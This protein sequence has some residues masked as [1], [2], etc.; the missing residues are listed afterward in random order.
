MAARLRRPAA[1]KAKA[2]NRR[3]PLAEGHRSPKPLPKPKRARAPS[4][5]PPQKTR[6]GDKPLLT[7]GWVTLRDFKVE[8]G[9]QLHLKGVFQ[10]DE[11]ERVGEVEAVLRDT[12]GEWMKLALTGSPNATIREWKRAQAGEFY[13]NMKPL[14]KPIDP[15]LG[16]LFSVVELKEVDQ[17]V[18]PALEWKSNLID[19]IREGPGLPGLEQAAADLGY[20]VGGLDPPPMRPAGEEPPKKTQKTERTRTRE[21]NAEGKRLVGYG[22]RNLSSSL[23]VS[24]SLLADALRFAFSCYRHMLATGKE[25]GGAN[26]YYIV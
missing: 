1:A 22:S 4:R 20:G 8:V 9:Q 11:A 2:R 24:S 17:E 18:D 5:R 25:N 21:G 26:S 13:A 19:L 23:F 15:K 7:S 10:G 14:V 12:E 3:A 16:G 6:A